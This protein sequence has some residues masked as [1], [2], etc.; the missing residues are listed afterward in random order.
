MPIR[1]DGKFAAGLIFM[2]FAPSV[3]SPADVLVARRMADRVALSLWREKRAEASK[4]ADVATARAA[5][6][7]G[8]VRQLTEELDARTGFR[9]VV[10]ESPR[11]GGACL[12]RPRRSPDRDDRPAAGRFRNR[13]RGHRAFSASRLTALGRAV[14]CAQ[15]RRAAGAALQRSSSA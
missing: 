9:K 7:E 12:R 4:R 14:R 3:Y 11:S 15:L 1:L 5:Q 6:L 2:S 13:Q 8:R 10:G